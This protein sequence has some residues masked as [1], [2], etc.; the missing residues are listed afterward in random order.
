MK[1]RWWL[2]I[3]YFLEER[4]IKMVLRLRWVQRIFLRKSCG[5]VKTR[6]TNTYLI[7]LLQFLALS[8]AYLFILVILPLVFS[9]QSSFFYLLYTQFLSNR[10]QIIIIIIN[11]EFLQSIT[12]NI[13]TI[14]S[15]HFIISIIIRLLLPELFDLSGYYACV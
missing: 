3:I 1:S 11:E 9:M 6:T 5:R 14:K 4:R 8:L 12:I 15:L 7:Q 10:L 13:I 2:C